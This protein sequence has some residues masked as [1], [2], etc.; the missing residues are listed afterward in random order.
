VL[1]KGYPAQRKISGGFIWKLGAVSNL[2]TTQEYLHDKILNQRTP[3][4]LRRRRGGRWKGE[5]ARRLEAGWEANAVHRSNLAGGA[6]KKFVR[7][8]HSSENDEV[9]KRSCASISMVKSEGKEK[10]EQS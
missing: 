9:Q 1:T 7:K 8:L 3:W 5:R 10:A 2:Q 6:L 4:F